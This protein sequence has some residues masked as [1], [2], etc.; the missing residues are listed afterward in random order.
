MKELAYFSAPFFQIRA[1]ILSIEKLNEILSAKDI[2]ELSD[3]LI[4]F[5]FQ[6]AEFSDA[7][8]CASPSLH[9]QLLSSTKSN[10]IRHIPSL[11]NYFLRMATRSTPFGLFSS[12]AL[13]GF[14]DKSEFKLDLNESEVHVQPDMEWVYQFLYTRAKDETFFSSLSVYK[15]PLVIILAKRIELYDIF[16][17]KDI[18]NKK[19]SKVSIKKTALL[20]SILSY[21]IKPI[22]I[23]ELIRKLMSI[24][25]KYGKSELNI[26]LQK[27]FE[28]QILLPEALPPTCLERYL[29][30]Y[31][32]GIILPSEC[33]IKMKSYNKLPFNNKMPVE[34]KLL[35]LIKNM[36]SVS[37]NS[38]PLHLNV[39]QSRN[40][41]QISNKI[42]DSI[43]ES[44]DFLW[45][46]LPVKQ[47][48]PELK[49]YH[50]K[51]VEKYG[52]NR[53]VP[54][55]EVI[56]PKKGI[57]IYSNSQTFQDKDKEYHARWEKFMT[58]AWQ[59][60]LVNKCK[61]IVL[62][63][64]HLKLLNSPNQS[65]T[66]LVPS[67][68]VFGQIFS[69]SLE[70]ID[71]GDFL[72][73]LEQFS[74]QGGAS[75]GRFMNHFSDEDQRRVRFLLEKEED[76]QPD[77]EFLEITWRPKNIKTL[78]VALHQPTRRLRL[79]LDCPPT[80]DSRYSV[81]SLEDLY[82]WALNDRFLLT[83]KDGKLE[84]HVTISNMVTLSQ[85]PSIVQLMRDITLS[86]YDLPQLFSWGKVYEHAN[87]LPRVRFKNTILS[88]E[89]W[90]YK[91]NQSNK[92]TDQQMLHQFNDWA[93][94]WFLPQETFLIDKDLRLYVN[95]FHPLGKKSIIKYLK[96]G[97]TLRF[98]QINYG[99]WVKSENGHHFSEFICSLYRNSKPS[100]KKL[101]SVIHP[102]E[103]IELG[104][105][106]KILGS[107]WIY[108][109]VYLPEKEQDTFLIRDVLPF[110]EYLR[111]EG[112]IESW[113]FIRYID[114][115]P[116]L[117]LRIR[118]ADKKNFSIVFE[119][120]EKIL[121]QWVED[122]LISLVQFDPYER[123]IERYGGLEYIENMETIFFLD[124][125]ACIKLK[126]FFITHGGEIDSS[127]TTIIPIILFLKQLGQVY[128]TI[129][130]FLDNGKKA[131][132]L[133]RFLKEN[134]REIF[135]IFRDLESE[136]INLPLNQ[137][138]IN[139]ISNRADKLRAVDIELNKKMSEYRRHS[140]YS[141]LLH[142]TC[143]RL[144]ISPNEENAVYMN[145][146]YILERYLRYKVIHPDFISCKGINHIPT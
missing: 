47:F 71:R 114:S 77:L 129:I 140:V 130:N 116:H 18:S 103:K 119:R 16:H 121:Y 25:E 65:S 96:R 66:K 123:E 99:A 111:L 13:L 36:R 56:S 11:F 75:L 39:I 43:A 55:L 72:I 141:S 53:L 68:D 93:D 107:E 92:E 113:F 138:L 20:N 79:E 64:T 49:Q 80:N 83:S 131:Y 22:S 98:T 62:E 35:D 136:A 145:V 15:N 33:Y 60:C 28:Q 5:F 10:Y 104:D 142:M 132:T 94:R 19:L 24:D 17:I 40:P 23:A 139:L 91:R 38:T 88:P 8:L 110:F 48:H 44:V 14:G 108:F 135:E 86:R 76:L 21:S 105:R 115:S 9:A 137:V 127:I 74:W 58:D 42:K 73:S 84:F 51:F 85:A 46:I 69:S 109:K 59:E 50:L 126:E 61:E 117:R 89:I 78:N 102:Y 4:T 63:E 45:K 81:L 125:V 30:D 100:L 32:K 57:G 106:L 90:I 146:R 29:G 70:A 120:I 134:A 3:A 143:N 118:L 26:I 128:Q 124:S 82:I 2:V 37:Y 95:R 1:S 7:I 52:S 87:F 67:I 144:G 101:S 97:L 12:L 6:N 133:S 41:Y 54:I 27:L 112:V 31:L 34:S 122:E